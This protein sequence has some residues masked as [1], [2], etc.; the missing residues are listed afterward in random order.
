[1]SPGHEICLTAPRVATRTRLVHQ[2]LWLLSCGRCF[3]RQVFS[4]I[5]RLNSQWDYN[6]GFHGSHFFSRVGSSVDNPTRPV[7]FEKFL[8][9][10]PTR[11]MIF[12]TPPYPTR[13]D[14]RDLGNLLTGPASW[15]M[16]RDNPWLCI[17][18]EQN[19]GPTFLGTKLLEISVRC[20]CREW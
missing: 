8:S 7:K 16:V 20:F 17:T 9:R 2:Q 19:P 3:S 15:A 10:D 13:L 6:Q 11:T 14:P 1:M 18:F 12:R 4:S 5:L